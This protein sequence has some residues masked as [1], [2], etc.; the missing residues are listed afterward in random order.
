MYFSRKHAKLRGSFVKLLSL[1]LSLSLSLY[2]RYAN[3]QRSS[4][5]NAVISVVAFIRLVSSAVTVST[6]FA[7]KVP[8]IK[9]AH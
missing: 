3:S 7:V 9:V 6:L 1:S 2:G 4:V 8:N 5:S